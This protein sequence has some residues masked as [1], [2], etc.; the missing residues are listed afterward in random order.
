MLFAK[1][2][3]NGQAA[4]EAELGWQTVGWIMRRVADGDAHSRFQVFHFDLDQ[5]LSCTPVG[6]GGRSAETHMMQ[7]PPKEAIYVGDYEAFEDL[8]ADLP[9]FI[10][11]TY[12]ATRLHS[13]LGSLNPNTF[14]KINA[15]DG[16]KSAE[17]TVHPLGRIPRDY[18]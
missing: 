10:E 16:S 11:N 2:P 5:L 17:E 4:L 3:L 18:P 15:P 8:V 9:K 6:G 12:N 14:E 7:N 1:R 13:V